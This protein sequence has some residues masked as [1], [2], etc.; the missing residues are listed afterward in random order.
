MR[1][2]YLT[3]S[4]IALATLGLLAGGAPAQASSGGCDTAALSQPFLP[5][6]DASQYQL[7]PGGDFEAQASDWTLAGDA[8]VVSGNESFQVTDPADS[9]SLSLGAGGTATTGTVCL[10]VEDPTLRLFV[11]NDGSPLSLLAVSVQFTDPS[12][13]QQ[14]LPLTLVSA[15]SDWQPTAQ[16]PVALNLLSLPLLS[17]GATNVNFSFTPVGPGGDWTID[18]VYLDPFKTK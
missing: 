14:S 13:N 3:L 2:R 16:I 15:G 4:T 1:A 9:H 12:G 10:A 6:Y 11:R 18:D 7:V 17:S 5:W 8:Q